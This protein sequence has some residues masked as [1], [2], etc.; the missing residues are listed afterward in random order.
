MIGLEIVEKSDP[1]G[2]NRPDH[3]AARRLS[4]NRAID[5]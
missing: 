1:I 4:I 2:K 3:R 5:R